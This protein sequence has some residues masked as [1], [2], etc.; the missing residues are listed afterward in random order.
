MAVY[1]RALVRGT[2]ELLV[3]DSSGEDEF[4]FY[5]DSVVLGKDILEE[6]ALSPVLSVEARWFFDLSAGVCLRR[7]PNRARVRVVIRKLPEGLGRRVGTLLDQLILPF[8]LFTDRLDLL[9]SAA[10]LAVLMSPVPQIVTVH[11]LFQA[12]PPRDGDRTAEGNPVLRSL[13]GWL[14][15]ACYAL[16]FRLQFR[17]VSHV[18][19]DAK[20]VADD[21]YRRF[22]FDAGAIDAVPLGLDEVFVRYRILCQEDP[23]EHNQINSRWCEAKE[24]DPGYVLVVAS[25]DPRKN[26]VRTLQAFIGLEIE[27]PPLVVLAPNTQSKRAAQRILKGAAG[28]EGQV[29]YVD[30]LP[31]T[32]LPFLFAN[33]AVVLIPTLAEGFGLPALEALAAGASVVTADLE[34][35]RSLPIQGIY[36]C[37]PRDVESIRVALASAL[38]DRGLGKNTRSAAAR[39]EVSAS[40]AVGDAFPLMN[41]C[42]RETLSLYKRVGLK[43]KVRS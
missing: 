26:L 21:I 14:I 24:I 8:F 19:T 13:A 6:I 43:H 32:E 20:W 29:K 40:S 23:A 25:S 34:V 42:I 2:L 37:E 18:I 3:R 30:W 35:L 39:R 5:G 27:R 38:T 16:F 12:W 15:R 33:A 10:N 1:A 28:G 11:D 31:R 36:R 4:V 41:K 22:L 17:R 9:H 7:L